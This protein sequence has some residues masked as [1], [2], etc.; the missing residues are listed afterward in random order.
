[1]RIIKDNAM[2]FLHI[3]KVLDKLKV[4]INKRRS[5]I[6]KM[7][8][9]QF[10]DIPLDEFCNT[11][12]IELRELDCPDCGRIHQECVP[13]MLD[14]CVG[15]YYDYCCSVD[16]MAFTVIP[17][18]DRDQWKMFYQIVKNQLEDSDHDLILETTNKDL[19]SKIQ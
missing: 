16:T 7:N 18:K 19:L 1:M 15:L 8:K 13:F 9:I 11:Y 2:K 3:N 6:Q 4:P 14:D 5:A 17:L 12:D 10:L